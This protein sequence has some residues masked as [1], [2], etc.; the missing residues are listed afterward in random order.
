MDVTIPRYIRC[1]NQILNVSP[2]KVMGILNLTPDSFYSESRVKNEKKLLEKAEKMLADGADFLDLGGYSSRPGADFV[3]EEEE[4]KRILPAIELL[5]K[6]FPLAKISVDT[7]RAKIAREA[8]EAGACM[9][10]DISGGQADERMFDTVAELQVPYILMHMRG[11][12]QTMQQLTDYHPDPITEINRFFSQ[13]IKKLHDKH[14]NDIIIDPGF[15]FAKTLEQ[16]YFILKNLDRFLIHDKILLVGISRKSMLYKLLR[17][18]QDQA[19]NAT[20]VA[21]T[22]G[23]LKGASILRVHDVK[24]AKEVV[25]IVDFMNQSG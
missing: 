2:A 19:L 17:I 7:F 23:L 8:I 4:R 15:G 25:K 9:I 6:H 5:N 13:K 1:N 10:N 20:T 24:E 11:T 12:P 18:T 3:S 16:N 14:V 21:H 22:I